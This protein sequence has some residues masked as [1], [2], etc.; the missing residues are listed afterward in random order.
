MQIKTILTKIINV[1]FTK[2]D[3]LIIKMSLNNMSA[4]ICIESN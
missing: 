3:N 4:H 2:Y 1:K